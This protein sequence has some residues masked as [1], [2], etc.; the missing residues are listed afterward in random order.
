M[1]SEAA[2]QRN[3][4]VRGVFYR[5]FF[6]RKKRYSGLDGIRAAGAQETVGK[7]P[8]VTNAC[9]AGII[10]QKRDYDHVDRLRPYLFH[11]KNILRFRYAP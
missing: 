7:S 10:C 9:S 8:S 6:R 1:R 2:I 3:I 5:V 4:V 11:G